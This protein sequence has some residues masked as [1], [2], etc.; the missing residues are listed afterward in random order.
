MTFT[1]ENEKVTCNISVIYGSRTHLCDLMKKIT[2]FSFYECKNIHNNWERKSYAQSVFERWGF[3]LLLLMTLPHKTSVYLG[4]LNIKDLWMSFLMQDYLICSHVV[5][6]LWFKHETSLRGKTQTQ[7]LFSWL[8]PSE[9]VLIT[10][11][12]TLKER[13]KQNYL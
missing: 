12:A 1:G 9:V 5:W 10:T 6:P 13:W 11:P 8:W 7:L 2:S 3:M 4:L